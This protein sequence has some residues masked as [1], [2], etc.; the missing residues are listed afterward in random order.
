[1]NDLLIISQ[2]IGIYVMYLLFVIAITG[3]FAFKL[4][5]LKG[6]DD[7]SEALTFSTIA[8]VVQAAVAITAIVL[9]MRRFR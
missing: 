1:M 2:C 7:E 8:N 6:M 9:Y 3:L 5:D 4:F